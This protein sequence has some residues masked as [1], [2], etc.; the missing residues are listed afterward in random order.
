[1]TSSRSIPASASACRSAVGSSAAVAPVTPPSLR[2]A[3]S[4]GI[5]IV[6]TVFGATRPQTY[7][8]VG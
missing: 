1:M 2:A 8:V 5:G 6:F 4:V 7:S 3:S